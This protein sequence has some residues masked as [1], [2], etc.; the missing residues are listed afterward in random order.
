MRGRCFR[1]R[2]LFR[3]EV[4]RLKKTNGANWKTEVISGASRKYCVKDGA[5]LWQNWCADQSL[6]ILC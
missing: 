3:A 1:R 2:Q 6:A 5:K 4:E